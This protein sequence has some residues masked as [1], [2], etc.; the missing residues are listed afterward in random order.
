MNRSHP[1]LVATLFLLQSLY[2]F[3][4]EWTHYGGD[5]GNRR[6]SPLKEINKYN[7]Q[8]LEAAWI[9]RTGDISDGSEIPFRSAFECTPLMLDGVLYLTTPFSR[10]IALDAETG[11]ELW[12][13]DPELDRKG[14]YNLFINR[15]V[16]AWVGENETRIFAGTLD[17]RLFA[18]NSKT[19]RPVPGFGEQG[20]VDL[21]KGLTE[22]FPGQGYGVTSPP[23]VYR[24][25]VITGSLVADSRPQGPPGDIRAFNVHTGEQVWRFHTVPRP[26]EEGHDTWEGDSWK[27][28]G[29]TNAWPGL[30]CDL[31]R[32][33]L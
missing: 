15:G 17:G 30:S 8:K 10:V 11:K 28:R 32:G 21:R 1:L 23:L 31:D 7:V 26:G 19:G 14:P 12:T 24:D 4:G 20:V 33:I 13:F 18:L 29:G 27:D 22:K 25:L 2:L 9:Y 3:S 16:A 5:A 6:Y